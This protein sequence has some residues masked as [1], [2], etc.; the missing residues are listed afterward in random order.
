MPLYTG[1]RTQHNHDGDKKK[2]VRPVKAALI[3]WQT[4]IYNSN[5]KLHGKKCCW[6][7]QKI[8]R[9]LSTGALAYK[10]AAEYLKWERM[11]HKPAF[12]IFNTLGISHIKWYSPYASKS[13][14]RRLHIYYI[15]VQIYAGLEHGNLCYIMAFYYQ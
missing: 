5:Y 12:V 1:C 15:L 2:P 6:Q 10:C 8:N 4:E 13:R 9:Y 11:A 3:A 7:F 14:S